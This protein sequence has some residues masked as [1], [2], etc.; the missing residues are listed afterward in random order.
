VPCESSPRGGSLGICVLDRMQQCYGDHRQQQSV[1]EASMAH[2][3][4]GVTGIN[5]NGSPLT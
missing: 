1:E 4:P 5:R 2:R 3:S